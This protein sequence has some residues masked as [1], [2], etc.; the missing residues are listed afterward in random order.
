MNKLFI[1]VH[2]WK[3][4]IG[5]EQTFYGQTKRNV[6]GNSEVEQNRTFVSFYSR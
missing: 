3:E 6:Y 2:Q 5:A 4:N 1:N